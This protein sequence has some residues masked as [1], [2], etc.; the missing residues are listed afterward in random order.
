MK[1]ITRDICHAVGDQRLIGCKKGFSFEIYGLDF[2]IDEHGKPWLC[3]V[4]TNPSL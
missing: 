4:N 1:K 2:L 3:E